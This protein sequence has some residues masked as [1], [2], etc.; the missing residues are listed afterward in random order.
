MS[1]TLAE[2]FEQLTFGELAQTSMGGLEGQA[3]RPEDWRRL[4][5]H[6]NLGL[7]ELHKRFFL[8][9]GEVLIQIFDH[10]S[11]YHLHPRYAISNNNSTELYRYILDSAYAPFQDDVLKIEEIYNVRGEKV[12]LNDLNAPCSLFTPNYNTIQVPLPYAEDVMG[13]QY[14]ANHPKIQWSCDFDPKKIEVVLA[15]G[16]LEALLLFV[17]SRVLKSMGGEAMAEGITMME[18]FEKSCAQAAEM[19][20]EITPH[21]SNLKLDYRGWV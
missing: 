6:V 17:G 10:I 12:C 5:A 14:R 13:V 9:T 18:A 19:G 4:V 15:D 21:Y 3:V 16:L 2:V 11:F 1:L 8:R 20:L 7:T